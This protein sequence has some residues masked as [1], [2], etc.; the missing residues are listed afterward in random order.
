VAVAGDYLT[1][2]QAAKLL[3]V[4]RW[5]VIRYA[6]TG[7]IQAVTLPSGDRRIPKAEVERLLREGGKR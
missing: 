4:S 6:A 1:T 2:G 3:G 5:T 7:K